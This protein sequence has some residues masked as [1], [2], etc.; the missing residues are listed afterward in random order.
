MDGLARWW[1]VPS[2]SAP[3]TTPLPSTQMPQSAMSLVSIA[4]GDRAALRCEFPPGVADDRVS[5]VLPGF[6]P[7]PPEFVG[8]CCVVPDHEPAAGRQVAAQEPGPG[9]WQGLRRFGQ[10]STSTPNSGM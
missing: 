10:A 4:T 1:Q 6:D 8:V 3:S 2:V 9:F 7:G 5:G